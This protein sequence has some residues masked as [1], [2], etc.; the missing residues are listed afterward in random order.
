MLMYALILS[1]LCRSI[2]SIDLTLSVDVFT[3]IA[4]IDDIDGNAVLSVLE[5]HLCL[6][7]R[8]LSASDFILRVVPK[9]K[10]KYHTVFYGK[11]N[12]TGD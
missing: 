3:R 10:H 12:Y 8:G 7:A 5:L 2:K 4:E 6:G 11:S 9:V 1:T